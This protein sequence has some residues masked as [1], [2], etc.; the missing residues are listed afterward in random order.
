M[1]GR[2]VRP[3]GVWQRARASAART[4]ARR[5]RYVDLLRAVCIG[6]VVVGH[7]L[8]AAPSVDGGDLTLTH[9]LR[10]SPW[11][12][13]LTWI[14]QVI[15]LFFIVGGF[16]NHA[17]WEA[18]LR[19]GRG[20]GAWLGVRLRRLVVPVVPLVAVWSL[21]AIAAKRIGV[22]DET[23][24]VASDAAF[25]PTWFLAVYLMLVVVVPL[26]HAL[27]RRVGMRSF[28]LFALAA[29]A[30][31]A[32]GFGAGLDW[33]RWT[34]Y[35]FVWLGAQQLGY[36]WRT[37]SLAGRGTALAWSGGA[38]A[39]L[40]VLVGLASYPISMITVP[41][42]PVSNSRPPTV[43]LLALGV[44]QVSLLRLAER[45]ARRW[46]ERERPWTATVL[47]NGSIMTLYLW[48]LTVLVWLVGLAHLFG[49]FGLRLEPGSAAWWLTRPVWITAC[50]AVLGLCVPVLARFE[51]GARSRERAAPPA[52]QGI[53]GAAGVCAGLAF[54]AQNGIGA[55][56]AL[57]VHVGAVALTLS[58]AALTLGLPRLGA[59][60]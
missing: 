36:A 24:R 46:L 59:A 11:T 37:G 4:P 16:A 18:A 52:W 40:I 27:W 38:L 15:P 55:P 48:H 14:F 30:V 19:D 32:L 8:M 54:L 5:N 7:W 50:A 1:D 47:V 51:Q 3:A 33:L 60:R 23:I 10:V 26:T 35:A 20:Y 12:Q 28:W 31:D 57:G 17:S 49:G 21:M 9:M 42:E 25:T 43:A 2:P 6:V 41:G 39:L 34:N 58:A 22:Q 53:V 45:P 29:A 13:W 44:L 56:G